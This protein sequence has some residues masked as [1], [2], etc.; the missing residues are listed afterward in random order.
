MSASGLYA[1]FHSVEDTNNGA[2]VV[3]LPWKARQLIIT[4]DSGSGGS[5]EFKFNES[6]S[7]GTLKTNETAQ[8]ELR[9]NTVYLNSSGNTAYRIWAF[10]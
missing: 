7:Y 6:E 8:V 1:N 4:N 5:L 10:G 9:T 3:T 2:N